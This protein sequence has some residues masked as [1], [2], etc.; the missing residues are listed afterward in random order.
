VQ[1]AAILSRNT[2]KRNGEGGKRRRGF[3]PGRRRP[4]AAASAA[5]GLRKTR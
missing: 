5:A 4:Q 1:N 3:A 2:V